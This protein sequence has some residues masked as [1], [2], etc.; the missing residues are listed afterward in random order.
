MQS[1]LVW[2]RVSGPVGLG[3]DGAAQQHVCWER[4]QS[5]LF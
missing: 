5:V 2:V 3:R 4:L 1:V